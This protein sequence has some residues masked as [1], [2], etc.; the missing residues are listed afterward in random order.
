M[1]A[2]RL[3]LKVVIGDH[4]TVLGPGK[5]ALLEAIAQERSLSKAA[6][7]IGMSYRRAWLLIQE[8][9]DTLKEPVLITQTGGQSGGGSQ[10]TAMAAELIEV[11][12]QLTDEAEAATEATRARVASMIKAP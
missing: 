4:D 1:N 8:L 9:N 6:K 2:P 10:L 3:K 11:Y 7:S 12:Q 5:I